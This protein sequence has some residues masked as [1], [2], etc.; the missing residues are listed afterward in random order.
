MKNERNH[1]PKTVIFLIT[2]Q[3]LLGLSAAASGFMMMRFPDGRPMHMPL[4]MLEGTPFSDFFIPGILL[5]MFVGLYPLAVTYSLF[6]RPAWRW[7]DAINPFRKMH[8]AWTASLAAGIILIIWICVQMMMLAAVH[9]LHVLYLVW[10]VGI[11][12]LTLSS[13]VRYYYSKN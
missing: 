6:S 12:C 11:I 10:G 9:F 5:F 3:G 4:S 8:W 2:L 7:P 1:R 13:R